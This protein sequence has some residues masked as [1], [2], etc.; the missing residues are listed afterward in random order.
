MHQDLTAYEVAE[1]F[2]VSRR[3]IRRKVAAG[4]LTPT[5]QLPGKTGAQLFDRADAERIFG[6]PSAAA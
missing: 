6:T 3:T 5:R 1:T 2:G 4:L